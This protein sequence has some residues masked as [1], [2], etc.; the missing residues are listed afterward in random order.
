MV[1]NQFNIARVAVLKSE[2]HPP[3]CPN[4]DSVEPFPIPFQRMQPEAG[5][6]HIVR[7]GRTIEHR[8][9]ILDLLKKISPNPFRLTVFKQ[10][11]SAL[12]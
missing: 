7:T 1:V 8:K 4:R 10:P 5:Q 11:L 2:D 6:I 3:V 12:C 9:D